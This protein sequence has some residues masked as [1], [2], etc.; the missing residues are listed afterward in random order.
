MAIRLS[1]YGFKA[2]YLSAALTSAQSAA[3]TAADATLTGLSVA[4]GAI[5][6]GGQAIPVHDIA[7]QTFFI[8]PKKM[9][10]AHDQ[11]SVDAAV[12]IEGKNIPSFEVE[13]EF[14]NDNADDGVHGLLYKNNDGVRVL[15]VEYPGDEN[16]TWTGV[17]QA[18]GVEPEQQNAGESGTR[19][20]GVTFRNAGAS[21]PVWE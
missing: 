19:K 16:Q 4:A 12:K 3:A 17:V 18:F 5:T 7:K 8:V 21:P 2:V 15:R 14:F 6:I 9:E 1:N 10:D 20:F 13:A 11:T